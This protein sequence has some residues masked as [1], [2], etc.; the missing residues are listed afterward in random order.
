VPGLS[1]A[2]NLGAMTCIAEVVAYLD[3][4]SLAEPNWLS[5]LMQEFKDPLVMAVTGSI[6]ALRVETEA[7]RLC[8]LLAAAQSN[9]HERR[10]IDSQTPRWFEITNFGGIG[11]G[12]NMAFR[13]K[14]FEV[15][16]GF[17]ERLG[18]GAV[19]DGG[20]EHL[21]FFSLLQ[22]GF[23]VAYSPHAVVRH[24]FPRDMQE[25]RRR[26]LRALTSAA[27]YVT[28]LF[29]EEPHHRRALIKYVLD[30]FRGT[31]RSWRNS[32]GQSRPVIVSRP[33][34]LLAW[35]CGPL[36]YA[37][38]GVERR[39]VALDSPAQFSVERLVTRESKGGSASR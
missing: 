15:W 33:R 36:L 12:G 13:R 35:L 5:I 17:D 20:E 6:K 29:V 22:R 24:P 32:P 37:R 8:A 25:L 10:V 2:R 38:A 7:E 11:D 27:A 1:R 21:A 28:L 39:H 23:R 14:A 31:P 9:G 18:R 16:P 3:D 30:G 26:K 19:I 4:D 34:G